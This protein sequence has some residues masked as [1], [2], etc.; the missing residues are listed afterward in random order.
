MSSLFQAAESP[1]QGVCF[2]DRSGRLYPTTTVWRT[3]SE[4]RARC[5]ALA[6]QCVPRQKRE[7]GEV[8]V[9]RV[10]EAD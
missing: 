8:V 9:V 4:A 6:W 2:R 3:D 1:R 7:G 10:V 5:E